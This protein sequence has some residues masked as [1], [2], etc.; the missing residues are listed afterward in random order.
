MSLPDTT[1]QIQSA[2]ITSMTM[3]VQLYSHLKPKI[4]SQ[5]YSSHEVM[6]GEEIEEIINSPICLLQYF[7]VL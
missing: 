5:W 6:G 1:H 4:Q 2:I 3:S 7:T